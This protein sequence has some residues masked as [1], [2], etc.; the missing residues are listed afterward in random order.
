MREGL[1]AAIQR[2]MV[3]AY[4]DDLWSVCSAFCAPSGSH[5]TVL[6]SPVC[7]VKVVAVKPPWTLKDLTHLLDK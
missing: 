2:E 3:E 5:A 4:G 7:R 1:A 6:L